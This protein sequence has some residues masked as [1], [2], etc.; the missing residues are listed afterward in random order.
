M[1]LTQTSIPDVVILEPTVFGDARGFFIESY[2][3]LL[4]EKNLG[5]PIDFVQDN[6]SLSA[7]KGTIRGLH[8]QTA[9]MAQL[10]LVRVVAGAIL[11]VVVDIRKNSPTLGKW[12]AQELTAAN[13]K[14]LLIPRGFAHAFCTL[15][16]NTE[17]L[18]K[19]DNYYS[20][21][22]DRGILWNDP[23]LNIAWPTAS[24]ILSEKDKTLPLFSKI[25]LME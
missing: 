21:A 23:A 3:K 13:K 10:K 15:E 18:Y 22:H 6:H 20:R 1:K 5:Y 19:T 8:F 2:N 7:E 9:P 4:L 17:V 12:V 24:P 14:Q 11:D 16:P 25:E